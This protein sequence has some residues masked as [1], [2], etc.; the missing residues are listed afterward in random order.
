MKL[1]STAKVTTPNWRA[2]GKRKGPLLDQCPWAVIGHGIWW[3]TGTIFTGREYSPL[4]QK[5]ELVTEGMKAGAQMQCLEPEEVPF[6][7]KQISQQFWKQAHGFRVR[8][9]EEL[10]ICDERKK[11]W[12]NGPKSGRENGLRMHR[13]ISGQH[14]GPTWDSWL[15]VTENCNQNPFSLSSL[16]TESSLGTWLPSQFYVQRFLL[17]FCSHFTK[18]LETNDEKKYVLSQV[19]VEAL[20]KDSSIPLPPVFW[21]DCWHGRFSALSTQTARIPSGVSEQDGR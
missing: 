3:T 14:W 17:A 16:V 7:I 8:M 2:L 6:W 15:A 1:L 21:L 9:R 13:R 5:R 20:D 19:W 4:M 18:S 11:V 10:S 12:H